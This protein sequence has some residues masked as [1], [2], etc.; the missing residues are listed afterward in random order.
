MHLTYITASL[1]GPYDTLLLSISVMSDDTHYLIHICALSS[2]AHISE[3][4]REEKIVRTEYSANWLR[5]VLDYSFDALL[6]TYPRPVNHLVKA[7]VDETVNQVDKLVKQ[8]S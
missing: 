3:S 8:L 1:S 4:K 5:S 7:L 2:A 6:M